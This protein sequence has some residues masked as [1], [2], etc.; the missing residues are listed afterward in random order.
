M[1]AAFRRAAQRSDAV[2]VAGGLGPT[3]DELTTEVL[4]KTFGRK[5][6]LDEASL[7]VIRAFLRRF[8]RPMP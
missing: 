2:I 5:L 1:A 7:E 3:R 4:A 6:V 8:G